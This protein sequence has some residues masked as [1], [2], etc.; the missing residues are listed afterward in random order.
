[1][2]GEKIL[3]NYKK[4]AHTLP[5]VNLSWPLYDKGLDNIGKDGAPVAMPLPEIEDDQLLVRVDSVG[6]CFSDIKLITQGNKHPRIFGRDLQTDPV[7]P[8]H[9]ASM[10]VVKV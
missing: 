8:G 1:M 2:S 3:A 9:E 7:I 10:T 6:L 5:D 4:A